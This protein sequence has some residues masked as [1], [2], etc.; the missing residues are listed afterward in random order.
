MQLNDMR[1]L[2]KRH[3]QV[4]AAIQRGIVHPLRRRP[5][6]LSARYMP[7]SNTTLP[8]AQHNPVPTD[9]AAARSELPCTIISP[10]RLL[11]LLAVRQTSLPCVWNAAMA[12]AR[13]V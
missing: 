7:A 11:C 13:C 3:A 10:P 8:A 12:A 1:R 9:T 2:C 6:E 4:R 5:V